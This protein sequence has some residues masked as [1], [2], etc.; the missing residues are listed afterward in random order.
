[1]IRF[2][3]VDMVYG[4]LG[5]VRALRDVSLRLRR[6]EHVVILGPN[7]A[8]KSTLL[9][10]LLGIARPTRGSVRW[11]A[12]I[13]P[14]IGFAPERPRLLP[15]TT[16]R[17]MLQLVA[18]GTDAQNEMR[19]CLEAL[20]LDTLLQRRTE[21]LSKGE[22]QRVSLAF[23]FL[24]SAPLV[25]LDEPFEG[26]DPLIRPVARGFI[27]SS[28]STGRTLITTTHRLEEV[29]EPF[30]RA[31]IINEGRVVQDIS[32]EDLQ[33]QAR[34]RVLVRP[35]ASTRADIATVLRE[36]GMAPARYVVRGTYDDQPATLAGPFAADAPPSPD[37][38][39]L[40]LETLLQLW[41]Q[42]QVS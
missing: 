26:L 33:E 28:M 12:G 18:N 27:L 11:E 13:R 32:V 37:L 16:V 30:L 39:P 34:G 31:L 20:H 6:G 7:G 9:R 36:Q 1:M 35:T 15:R 22:A 25:V 24:T 29:R 42:P 4:F 40:N 3:S 23:A 10:L 5:G 17:D 19:R 38:K 14:A 21:G 8:G 2:E 41:L